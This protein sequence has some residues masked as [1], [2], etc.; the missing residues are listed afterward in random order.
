MV[1]ELEYVR[2][3]LY[4]NVYPSDW[5]VRI[6]LDNGDVLDWIDLSGLLPSGDRTRDTDVLNGIAFDDGT[7]HFLVTGKLWPAL[8]EIRLPSRESDGIA[9]TP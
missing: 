4:A 9:G 7:G 2:G 5:L 1:N 8:F 3:E 6:D